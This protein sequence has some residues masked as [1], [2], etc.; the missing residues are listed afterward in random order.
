MNLSKGERVSLTKTR[1]SLK[2]VMIGLGWDVNKYDE[3]DF[4]LDASAFLLQDGD[5][6]GNDY[7]F[8]F[9]NNLKH[10]TGAIIHHGDNR[11]GNGDGDDEVIEINLDKVPERYNKIAIAV[12]IDQADIR[13]Q[14][15]GMVDNAYIRLLDNDTEI[16]R[17][18]L[19]ESFSTETAVV[20]AE[21]YKHNNEWKFK[22]VGSGYNG[23][24]L[25]LC[26]TY[27]VDVE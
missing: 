21:I 10:K 27:G 22:A 19:S 18:D 2:K 7:D 6:V 23:G 16:L 8:V 24:L 9:Y 26:N 11:T 12:S 14:N 15:F 5:R 20:V 1:P 25:T 3:A 4:D 13:L 17:F